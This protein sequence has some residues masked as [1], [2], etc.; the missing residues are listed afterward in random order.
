MEINNDILVNVH[1]ITNDVSNYSLTIDSSNNP[2][3]Y[4]VKSRL[5]DNTGIHPNHQR[6]L[7]NNKIINNDTYLKSLNNGQTNNKSLDVNMMIISPNI[8]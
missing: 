5:Y 1:L 4:A 6:I 3:I 7:F 2:T 8:M